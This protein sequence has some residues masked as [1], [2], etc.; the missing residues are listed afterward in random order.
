VCVCMSMQE[1]VETILNGSS[2]LWL[3]IKGCYE[4]NYRFSD[5]FAF[6]GDEWSEVWRCKILCLCVCVCVCVRVSVCVRGEQDCMQ[7]DFMGEE[8]DV[9]EFVG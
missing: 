5:E 9:S 7:R 3:Y 8:R 4:V 6:W 1:G 2:R